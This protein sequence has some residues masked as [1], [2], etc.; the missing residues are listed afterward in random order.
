MASERLDY[1]NRAARTYASEGMTVP[2]AGS[3]GAALLVPGSGR[4]VFAIVSAE[5]GEQGIGLHTDVG[6]GPVRAMIQAERDRDCRVLLQ[7]WRTLDDDPDAKAFCESVARTGAKRIEAVAP[8]TRHGRTY[9]D[10]R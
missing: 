8:R 1:P 9:L 6:V 5:Y 7:D 2:G 10:A 3:S 4:T